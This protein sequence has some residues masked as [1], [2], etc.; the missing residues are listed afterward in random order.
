MRQ[1]EQA[2]RRSYGGSVEKLPF[3]TFLQGR[4]YKNKAVAYDAIRGMLSLL[5]DP[6]TRLL[7]AAEADALLADLG[8][9]GTAT[10]GLTEVLIVLATMRAQQTTAAADDFPRPRNTE[11]AVGGPLPARDAAAGFRVPAGFHVSVFAAEPD[12]RNPIAMA[13]DGRGRL[14]IAENYTYAERA[15]AIRSQ[16]ARPRVDFRRHGRR[17][18]V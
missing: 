11:T 12:V 14:W 13:W 9:E 6:T 7:T 5:N 17:R 15:A 3:E 1:A 16:A 2:I 8:S 4:Q 10:L 18:T